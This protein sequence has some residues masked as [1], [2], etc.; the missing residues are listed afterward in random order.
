MLNL[1]NSNLYGKVPKFGQNVTVNIDGNPGIEKD[2]SFPLPG[3]A[4]DGS[5]VSIPSGSERGK[6]SNTG[7]FWVLHLLVLFSACLLLD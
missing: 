5:S 4:P 6:N 1:S 7:I 2:R 3:V